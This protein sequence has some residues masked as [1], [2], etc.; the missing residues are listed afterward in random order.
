MNIDRLY[1]GNEFFIRKETICSCILFAITFGILSYE[2]IFISY[3]TVLFI[4]RF[5][6]YV[7][8]FV[9][10]GCKFIFN[11]KFKNMEKNLLVLLGLWGLN[12]FLTSFSYDNFQ[13]EN[14]LD[15][16]KILTMIMAWSL[17]FS[18]T[19]SA[20]IDKNLNRVKKI[21]L[22][23]VFVY[24]VLTLLCLN[25][26]IAALLKVPGIPI[27]IYHSRLFGIKGSPNGEAVYAF[28]GIVLGLEYLLYK[29]SARSL[30]TFIY[31]SFFLH[32]SVIL[33]CE[34]RSVYVCLLVLMIS[35]IGIR[36][37]LSKKT[38]SILFLMLLA[39]GGMFFLSSKNFQSRLF[40]LSGR[41]VLWTECMNIPS[42]YP[43]GVGNRSFHAKCKELNPGMGRTENDVH[44]FILRSF[45]SYGV[46]G[47]LLTIAIFVSIILN[48]LKKLNSL[49]RGYLLDE[50][51]YLSS[52][53]LVSMLRGLVDTDFFPSFTLL[54]YLF[55]LYYFEIISIDRRSS[56]R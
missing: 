14:N 12:I 5:F 53:L 26:S 27:G 3:K 9:L 31:L 21:V 25:A 38:I 33:F 37:N 10:W 8:I 15:V 11:L 16:I 46:L 1:F 36:L 7:P 55:F 40:S 45:V 42:K 35:L 20:S 52:I 44:N 23:S 29:P 34:S 56:D 18:Y 47:G 24:S 39:L 4:S 48:I 2:N 41:E 19:P 51:L 54:S 17:F 43:L 32:L 13:L 49:K 22:F 50:K 30:K 28:I 6:I